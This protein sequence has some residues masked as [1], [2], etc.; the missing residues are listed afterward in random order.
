MHNIRNNS[1]YRP[2]SILA[3]PI[4]KTDRA[5][6]NN[7]KP[8]V[9][10]FTGLSG[11]GKSTLAY[12]LELR[13]FRQGYYCY[14]LDGDAFRNGLGRDLGF[15]DLGRSENIRRLAEVSRLFVEAGLIVISSFI[16]PFIEDRLKA[17]QLFQPDEFVEVYM[18]TPIEVCAKRDTKGLYSKARK[19]EIINFTGI[20]SKYE[21]PDNPEVILDS[22][23][24]TVEECVEELLNYLTSEGFVD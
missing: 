13:L 15:N 7:Q 1:D 10:W 2:H 4:T 9:I 21:P 16:S 20:D 12:A 23:S 22:S 11:S 17:R 14:V 18:S 19:G 3:N 8:G 5:K 24:Q 6:R